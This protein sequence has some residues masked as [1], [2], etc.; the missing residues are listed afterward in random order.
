M[1][2][3]MSWENP[4][5]YGIDV[6]KYHQIQHNAPSQDHKYYDNISIVDFVFILVGRRIS[7]P[8]SGKYQV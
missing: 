2:M 6:W 5:E 8:Q 1:I 4:F 3:T 7:N